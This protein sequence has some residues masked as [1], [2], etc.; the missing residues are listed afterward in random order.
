MF[1]FSHTP[2]NN[3]GNMKVGLGYEL[4][5][6]VVERIL[7]FV[8]VPK[9]CRLRTVCK[10]W[11]SSICSANFSALQQSYG[12][13]TDACF[14]VARYIKEIPLLDDN[15]SKQT[16]RK[17]CGWA[18]LDLNAKR[19]YTIVQDRE[20]VFDQFRYRSSTVTNA[21]LV[22]QVFGVN[23]HIE[24]DVS[25]FIS[26]PIGKASRRLPSPPC[27]FNFINALYYKS[28]VDIVADCIAHN[29][30][31]FVMPNT[32]DYISEDNPIIHV[33]KQTTN[34]WRKSSIPPMQQITKGLIVVRCSL[35]FN[36]MLYLLVCS[37]APFRDTSDHWL[38]SYNHVE[39]T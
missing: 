24:K 26:N 20:E 11:N 6:D 15:F 17:H 35:S 12:R 34:R 14:I 32:N 22:C 21:G 33:Y 30:K 3:L 37:T 31:V 38:W 2:E 9:L 27:S 29:H 5:F 23:S 28:Q 16:F 10:S 19:W 1:D 8:S 36:G 25:I 7:S 13:Q 18:F 39:D 4:S